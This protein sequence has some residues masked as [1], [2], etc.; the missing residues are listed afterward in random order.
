MLRF[1][2]E[3]AM[4][5]FTASLVG[6]FLLG[7][8][9][10]PLAADE[11]SL[12][13]WTISGPRGSTKV[14]AQAVA[15][16]QGVL[17][18]KDADG[19]LHTTPLADLSADDRKEAL[20]RVIG[21]GVVVV[22]MKSVLDEPVGVGSGFVFRSDGMILTNYHV[23]RGAGS[24]EIET[25]DGKSP[26]KA[27]LLAVDRP[28]DVAILKVEK[29]PEG[30]HVLE[31]SVKE[32]PKQGAAVWTIGHPERLKNTVSWGDVN[33]VRRT[34]DLPGELSEILSAAADTQWI[35]TDAV[36]AGGSSGGPLLNAQGQAMGMN[37]FIAGPQLGFA[38]HL[39]HA[40]SAFEQART[41]KA[42]SLPL[43][44]GEGESALSW[45]SRDVAPVLQAFRSDMQGLEQEAPTLA[46]EQVLVRARECNK[47]HRDAL[48]A[49]ARKDAA[50]WPGLQA[51]YYTCELSGDGSEEAGRA[52][53]EA[54]KMLTEHHLKSRD[55]M[56]IMAKFVGRTEPCCRELAQQVLSASPM[57]DA[58]A[59][60]AFALAMGKLQWI[61]AEGGLDLAATK[62]ARDDL[63]SL[64]KRLDTD[65]ADVAFGEY[66]AKQY[67]AQLGAAIAALR[68][69][70]PAAEIS[71]VDTDGKTFKLSEYKGKVVLLDFFADWCPYCRKMYPAERKLVEDLKDRKFALL[72]VNSDNQKVLTQLV[73][74]K[75]VTWRTWADGEQGPITTGWRID[76]FPNLFLVDHNGIVRRHYQGVPAEEELSQAVDQ[77]LNEAEAK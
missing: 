18:L 77:L 44:P 30:T 41:A 64:I 53:A 71:G 17:S 4:R 25:R 76:S 56:L 68:I 26:L 74:R 15:V 51:L 54:C 5:R 13:E 69:G 72:G 10:A 59:H 73:E 34:Q 45:L 62:A 60:A 46:R 23:V 24:I 36:L 66:T 33:A 65:F 3:V 19:K 42:L 28:N 6:C 8:A 21:S 50:G 70:Q 14:K 52:L 57:R 32:L 31:L 58:Q 40:R 61:G 27:E 63:Q 55:L 35:Q 67:A 1:L 38:L 43:A 2:F 39:S 20:I 47:K 75:A 16:R 48:L 12:R 11:G 7:V 37:T 29:L 9:W 49:I 22:N